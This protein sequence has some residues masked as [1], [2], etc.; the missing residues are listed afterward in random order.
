MNKK[1]F[2]V[3]KAECQKQG[4]EVLGC[5][6]HINKYNCR[7]LTVLAFT[8]HGSYTFYLEKHIDGRKKPDITYWEKGIQA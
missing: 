3:V 4:F 2:S 6:L 5:E 8:N 7:K 1:A